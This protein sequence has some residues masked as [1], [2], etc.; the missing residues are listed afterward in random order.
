MHATRFRP[1]L[2][3]CCIVPF[4]AFSQKSAASVLCV[5]PAGSQG[6]YSTIQAAV[7]HASSND[8]INVEV[9]T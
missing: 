8:V 9:G 5:N 3:V 1:F 6:C 7:N 4:G 2:I